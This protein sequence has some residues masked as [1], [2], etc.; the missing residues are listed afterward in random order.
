M[1]VFTQREENFPKIKPSIN[2]GAHR[3]S[4]FENMKEA[5]ATLG[6]GILLML[7]AA[8]VGLY[9]LLSSQGEIYALA[10]FL[11]AIIFSIV[12]ILGVVNT[13]KARRQI[14][15]FQH[16]IVQTD[17]RGVETMLIPYKRIQKLEID[18]ETVN[19]VDR[20]VAR[21]DGLGKSL[22]FSDYA[23]RYQTERSQKFNAFVKYLLSKTPPSAMPHQ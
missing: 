19:L 9:G 7:I 16:G 10:G 12:V 13:V 5:L 11:F 21:V 18:H 1:P 8:G 4:S 23:R 2:L 20:Y 15:L 17:H 6:V 3:F 14:H 22:R